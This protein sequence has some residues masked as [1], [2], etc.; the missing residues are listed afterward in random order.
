[1]IED[2]SGRCVV[3]FLRQLGV[4]KVTYMDGKPKKQFKP[5]SFKGAL[6]FAKQHTGSETWTCVSK[7]NQEAI[8]KWLKLLAEI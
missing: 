8:K 2:A 6:S 3:R 1:M 5:D 4:G 7:H